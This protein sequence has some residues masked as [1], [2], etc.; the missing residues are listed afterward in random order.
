MSFSAFDVLIQ[1]HS[2][3]RLVSDC[4]GHGQLKRHFNARA[5]R[6]ASSMRTLTHWRKRLL[7]DS[8]FPAKHSQ[9]HACTR[10]VKYKTW[11]LDSWTGTVQLDVGLK[12]GEGCDQLHQSPHGSSL[13]YQPLRKRKGLVTSLYYSCASRNVVNVILLRCGPQ[14]KWLLTK[15]IVH[16]PMIIALL[17]GAIN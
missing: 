10:M 4:Q 11:T 6:A 3:H 5:F 2:R 1:Y 17:T 15:I 8:A 16:A 13:G 7:P 12:I 9:F 14:L